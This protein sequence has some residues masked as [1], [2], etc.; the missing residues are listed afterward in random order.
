MDRNEID[1]RSGLMKAELDAVMQEAAETA[2]ADGMTAEDFRLHHEAMVAARF[3]GRGWKVERWRLD[4]YA[5]AVHGKY[6]TDENPMP[7]YEIAQCLEN[8]GDEVIA[9][10]M[11]GAECPPYLDDSLVRKLEPTH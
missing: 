11:T 5:T 4:A 6:F 9:S 8:A 7:D 2:R 3:S 1:A 10:V